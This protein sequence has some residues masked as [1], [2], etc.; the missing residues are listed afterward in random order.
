MNDPAQVEQLLPEN[1]PEWCRV[2]VKN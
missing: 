1:A 2:P